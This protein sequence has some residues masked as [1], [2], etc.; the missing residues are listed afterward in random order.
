MGIIRVFLPK[1][2]DM[3]SM[4]DKKDHEGDSDWKQHPQNDWYR[5]TVGSINRLLAIARRIMWST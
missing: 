3:A 2:L 4:K 5:C 1:L